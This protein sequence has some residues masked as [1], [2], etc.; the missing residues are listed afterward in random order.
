MYPLNTFILPGFPVHYLD[1]LF[2]RIWVLIRPRSAPTAPPIFRWLVN[3]SSPSGW[4]RRWPPS[5]GTIQASL[6]LRPQ[7]AL[8]T[9]SAAS[10]VNSRSGGTL[11]SA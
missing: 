7:A 10:R 6:L 2:G 11:R 4:P 8:D 9:S 5:A 3:T 1:E